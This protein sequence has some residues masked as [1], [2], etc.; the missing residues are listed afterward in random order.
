MNQSETI[1]K[2]D[3]MCNCVI[4]LTTEYDNSRMARMTIEKQQVFKRDVVNKGSRKLM[5]CSDCPTCNGSGRI[6]QDL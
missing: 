1:D 6:N 3:N 2:F 4:I 5:P